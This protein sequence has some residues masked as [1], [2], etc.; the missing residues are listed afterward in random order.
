MKTVFSLMAVLLASMAAHAK[1]NVVATTPDFGAI[2]REIGGDKVDVFTMAKPTEDAHFVDAKPSFVVKLN[3]ADALI[4]GG[5]E[6]EIAWLGPL[7]EQAR[8]SRLASGKPGRIACNQGIAMLEVPATLDRS[9]GDEHAA[10]NP[11]FTTDPANAKIAAQTIASAFTALDV[12]SAD[13]FKAN[14]EKFNQ[15]LDTKM[16]EWKKALA[17]YAGK[18]IAS[19]H[20]SWPYFTKRFELKG[21][22]FLEPKPGIPPSPAHLSEVIATMKNENVKIIIVEPHVN[23]RSADLVASRT[24][25][26][27]LDF[28]AYPGGK[29]VPDD[30][31]GW[32]D[33]LVQALAKAFAAKTK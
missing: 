27:V 30:Y 2:A 4:E 20:N 28:A 12:K 1:L 29:G 18:R 23:H 7:V 21:D 17:P 8:N 6:L 15:R 14:L 26:V 5:A 33:S 31:A 22:L 9:R 24:D 11:H 13:V 16:A 19:Y 10:G 3:K 25:A 32:M